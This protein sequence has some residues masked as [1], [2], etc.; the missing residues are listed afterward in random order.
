LK[1]RHQ[2]VV[3]GDCFEEEGMALGF[4]ETEEICKSWIVVVVV[5]DEP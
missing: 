2:Y 3:S 4:D 5:A 1:L